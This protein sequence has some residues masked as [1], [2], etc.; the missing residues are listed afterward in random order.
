MPSDY[1]CQYFISYSY[2]RGFGHTAFV[3]TEPIRTHADVTA[4]GEEIA[5]SINRPYVIVL[6]FQRFED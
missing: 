4:I 6:N 2:D 5:R 3:R 1:P